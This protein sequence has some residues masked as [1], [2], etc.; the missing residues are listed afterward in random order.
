M[1]GGAGFLAMDEP[2]SGLDS[3]ESA[4]LRQMLRELK[5]AGV[6]ILIIDHAV[7]EI[8]D[9]ADNVVVLDFGCVIARGTPEQ[10]RNDPKVQEAY[11]GIT[12][13]GTAEAAAH[14]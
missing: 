2:F 12:E 9:L 7:H 1:A 10:V 14:A 11:F 8:F 6:T 3:D 4:K 13:S 5:A